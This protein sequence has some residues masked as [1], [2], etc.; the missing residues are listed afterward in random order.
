[1]RRPVGRKQRRLDETLQIGRMSAELDGNCSVA[2]KV[3]RGGIPSRARVCALVGAILCGVLVAPGMARAADPFG[4]EQL[5]NEADAAIAQATAQISQQTA[6]AA[7]QVSPPNPTAHVSQE[8]AKSWSSAAPASSNVSSAQPLDQAEAA[9]ASAVTEAARV[10][11]SVGSAAPAKA[12]N[13]AAAP[14]QPAPRAVTR[15]ARPPAH[16]EKAS[17]VR[18]ALP[19]I[20]EQSTLQ[21]VAT[22]RVALSTSAQVHASDTRR[23]PKPVAGAAPQ[24]LPP[25]PLPPRPD[26]T[27]SGQGGGG[28]GPP[29]QLVVGALAAMLFLLGF[30]LL[31][32]VLPRP[33]FR[34]PRRIALPPWHPG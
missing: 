10:A 21:N 8:P 28:Q 13:G 26:T 6:Q 9:V 31:P 18:P 30:Q 15:R 7:A 25:L 22:P 24:R 33:A 23:S 32:R 16:R 34:K 11:S 20:S 19:R 4:T 14:A 1:M 5:L 3:S 2:A 29:V 27:S 17:A 12:W